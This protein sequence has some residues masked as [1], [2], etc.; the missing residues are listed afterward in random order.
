MPTQGHE[1]KRVGERASMWG[2]E[3]EPFGSS[4]YMFFPPPGPALC[5]LGQPGVLFILPE[6]LTLVLRP[7]LTFLFLF[8]WAFPFLFFQPPPFW[9]PVSYSNYLTGL[10]YQFSIFSI[11]DIYFLFLF[12]SFAAFLW[13]EYFQYF[14]LLLHIGLLAIFFAYF[15][16]I[17]LELTKCILLS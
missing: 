16:L 6:V 8:S 12:Q 10:N 4:F 2:R 15:L 17:A 14:I 13:I 1:E 11:C 5:K 7:S 9:T 3:R